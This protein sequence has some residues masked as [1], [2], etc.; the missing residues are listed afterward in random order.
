M[1]KSLNKKDIEGLRIEEIFFDRDKNKLIL[2]LS[3]GRV[4]T[5]TPDLDSTQV[6]RLKVSLKE[7]KEVTEMKEVEEFL[8]P[9]NF[10]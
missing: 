2:S 9:K 1:K 10:D 7:M 8:D 3:G 6:H 5:V 4:L